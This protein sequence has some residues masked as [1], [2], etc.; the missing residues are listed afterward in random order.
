MVNVNLV[1]PKI[2]KEIKKE[3][4]GK[5]TDTISITVKAGDGG[6]GSLSFRREKYVAKGGPDGGDGGKGGDVLLEADRRY[7]N[8]SHLY[9]DRLYKA[10]RGQPGSSRNKHGRDGEPLKVLVP[11]GTQVIDCETDEILFDLVDEA[12][13]IVV[14]EGGIGGKG[15]A[16]FKSSTHQTPRFAQPGMP[17]TERELR[18]DLKLIADIGLVGLPNAGKSSLLAALTNARPKIADY[19]FTTL[20]PNLGVVEAADG[21]LYKIADIPGIIE[22]AHKGHGLGLSF[23]QHIERVRCIFFLIECTQEDPL[24]NLD[25][26]MSELNSYSPDLA[27]KP[28][29]VLVSKADLLPPE[30]LTKKTKVL[31]KKGVLAISSLS[32]YNLDRIPAIIKK[33][34]R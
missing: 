11:P 18:L 26:L 1:F 17:G 29:F 22:G 12:D 16:F 23:L 10:E 19:P 27:G 32:G 30:E 3:S 33:M 5:F 8:L 21:K 25:L 6:P 24:Y 15:N 4:M 34:M 13:P 28:S 9:Q 20:I 14:A 2:R 31:A 7:Y